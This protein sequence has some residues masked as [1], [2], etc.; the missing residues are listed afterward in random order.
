MWVQAGR[1]YSA[2]FLKKRTRFLTSPGAGRLRAEVSMALIYCENSLPGLR[3]LNLCSCLEQTKLDFWHLFIRTRIPFRMMSPFWSSYL[4]KDSPLLLSIPQNGI[5]HRN[6]G[7]TIGFPHLL[8]TFRS[9]M[10]PLSVLFCTRE[11]ANQ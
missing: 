5:Q 2:W 10:L 4:L 9:S 11:T 7:R 8:N 1:L 6:F 3:T